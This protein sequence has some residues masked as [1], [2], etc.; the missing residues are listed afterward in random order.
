[1]IEERIDAVYR[2]DTARPDLVVRLPFHGLPSLRPEPALVGS[3]R[4]HR[5]EFDDSVLTFDKENLRARLVEMKAPP[6]IRR[7][8]D[9][10]PSLDREIVTLHDAM[11]HNRFAA[12]LPA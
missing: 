4:E 2:H 12:M 7:Q 1:M 5:L 8:C 11:Q 6:K 3:D 9:R 10:A